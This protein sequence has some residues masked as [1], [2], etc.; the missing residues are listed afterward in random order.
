M[1]VRVTSTGQTS[2]VKQVKV[3][4]PVRRVTSGAFTIDNLGGV[5]TTSKQD[6]SVLVY[7]ASTTNFE[8]TTTLDKQLINGGNF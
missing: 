4:T 6:G 3:G 2:F 1:T 8:A 5:D 7:N